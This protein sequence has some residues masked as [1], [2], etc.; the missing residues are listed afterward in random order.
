M[1]RRAFSIPSGRCRRRPLRSDASVGLTT[2]AWTIAERAVRDWGGEGAI[3]IA[4]AGPSA[5]MVQWEA[6]RAAVATLVPN[7]MRS[8]HSSY[9]LILSSREDRFSTLGIHPLDLA[10]IRRSVSGGLE[11][12]TDEDK[13]TCGTLQVVEI[14]SRFPSYERYL[15]PSEQQS[16]RHPVLARQIESRLRIVVHS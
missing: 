8:E 9:S 7:T 2:V 4:P 14:Y 16:S 10:D 3:R 12:A 1:H 6:S 5:T 11:S 15:Q 13:M